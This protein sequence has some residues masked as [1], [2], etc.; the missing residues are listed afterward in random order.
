MSTPGTARFEQPPGNTEISRSP[1]RGGKGFVRA[2]GLGLITGA[3]DDDPSAIG[4]YASAGAK[5][6]PSFLWIAPL[7][8]PMMVAVVYLSSKLGLVTGQG[9]FAVIRDHYSRWLL[10]TLLTG[11]IIGN[12]IEAGADIGGM[13]AAL[14]LLVPLP[15]G[16]IAVIT[17]LI[18]LAVQVW[19]S[20]E[21]I[22]NIFR[23]LAL[24][25][26]A[27]IGSALLA[28]PE[29]AAVLRGTFIPTIHFNK[30]FLSMVVAVIGTSLSA[31]IYTWQSN[32]EV[33]EKIAAGKRRLWQ[34]RGA[35]RSELKKSMWDVVVGMFFS[36]VVMYFIILST[37]STLFKA[38]K[39]D[40]STAA[41]AAQALQPLAGSAGGLLFALGV[42]GVGFLA[43]PVMTTGA[44]YDVCQS[45]GWKH[46]LQR[47]PAEAKK[48]YLAIAA[49]T[50]LAIGLNFFG[51]NPMKAL[52]LAGIVQG[53]STPPLMLLILLMTNNP[54]IMGK[55]VNSRPI[56]ILSWVTTIAIFAASVGL[57]IS[58]FV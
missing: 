1:E 21:L 34:R 58:W 15:I 4:T 44:A 57:V 13:A 3:A 18:I 40:I 39:T 20:Y 37:A 32:E 36:S 50:F 53:F 19:G 49:F 41:E 54:A 33:E 31:Y 56:R 5:F 28:H 11:V 48:F 38:G 26:L 16:V 8:F 35:S 55:R 12:I 10:W 30:D 45:L 22:R 24:A 9:L 46:G 27:Y 47:K 25:L 17:G 14:N 51:I 23:V 29:P 6:G 42:I 43:V 52:V 7:T 2:I